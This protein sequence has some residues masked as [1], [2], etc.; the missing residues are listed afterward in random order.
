MCVGA[1]GLTTTAASAFS[2]LPPVFVGDFP[3]VLG[4]LGVE[5]TAVLLR[6]GGPPLGVAA[7]L[8]VDG[9][10]EEVDVDAYADGLLAAVFEV[11]L[12]LSAAWT[13]EA[14]SILYTSDVKRAI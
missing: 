4:V 9:T 3:G 6:L 13:G 7:P 5:F 11:L 14:V 12:L 1:G 10:A 2:L 8:G